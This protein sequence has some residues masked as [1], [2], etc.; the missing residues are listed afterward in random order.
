[1]D[2]LNCKE[3]DDMQK[4][5]ESLGEYIYKF[6]KNKKHACVYAANIDDEIFLQTCSHFRYTFANFNLQYDDIKLVEECK[7]ENVKKDYDFI[8]ILDISYNHKKRNV[9][10]EKIDKNTLKAT[11]FVQGNEMTWKDFFIMEG[12]FSNTLY[13]SEY[14]NRQN[15][16]IGDTRYTLKKEYSYLEPPDKQSILLSKVYEENER[17]FN[18][19]K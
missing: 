9:K 2:A 8:L 13:K 3:H 15:E 11:Y 19:K 5:F 10:L 6:S 4:Y 18:E 16:K 1:M 12:N 7:F 14:I 17:K